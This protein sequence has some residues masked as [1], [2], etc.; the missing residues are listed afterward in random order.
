MVNRKAKIEFPLNDG[1]SPNDDKLDVEKLMR[2][3]IPNYTLDI[4]G[5]GV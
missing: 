2:N 1:S 4:R 5:I 3:Y